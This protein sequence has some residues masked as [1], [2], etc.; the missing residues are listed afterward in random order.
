VASKK[1]RRKML[2]PAGHSAWIERLIQPA[3]VIG[4]TLM[5]SIAA[6]VL[7]LDELTRILNGHGQ[8]SDYFVVS[9]C[10]GMGFL[11]DMAIIVS[12]THYKMHMMR[13]DPDEERWMNYAKS[14]LLLGLTSESLTLF[15]FFVHLGAASLWPP[16]VGFADFIHGVLAISR[17]F[18]P[19]VVIAYF[20]AGLLP[21][22]F[23]RGDR[24]R[25]IKVRTSANIMMLIDMLSEVEQTDDKNEML[26]A[27]GG[28]L[29]LDTYATYDET[30]KT[31]EP[32]QVARDV[33]LLKHLAKIN[34]LNWDLVADLLEEEKP[35]VKPV[36][37]VEEQRQ[38]E[39]ELVPFSFA[40]SAS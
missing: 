30:K 31:T 27:L 24:N 2:K 40:A 1:N 20:V 5:S 19:P 34:G 16:L 35:A 36:V 14:V 28:Q 21:V 39:E 32:E 12:A 6:Y 22:V 15:Y 13:A 25:E 17:A 4:S 10:A 8:G 38:E 23:G 33:K 3:I 29:V 11:V 9:L 7:G 37:K 26:K 18:L